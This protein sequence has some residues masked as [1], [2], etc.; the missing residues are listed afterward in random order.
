M[1]RVECRGYQGSGAKVVSQV[2][3]AIAKMAPERRVVSV[4]V[5]ETPGRCEH[6]DPVTLVYFV[7]DDQPFACVHVY[8][9]L[10]SARAIL[11]IFDEY[12][13]VEVVPGEVWIRLRDFYKKYG[14]GKAG[15]P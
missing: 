2:N 4:S 8:D 6:D 7:V 11:Q 9:E 15:Q 10:I 1:I 13:P 14:G 12:V 5:C 3:D